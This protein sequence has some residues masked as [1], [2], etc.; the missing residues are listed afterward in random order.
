MFNCC[1]GASQGQ[2]ETNWK[3]VSTRY[4]RRKKFLK[5]NLTRKRLP[6]SKIEC[7]VD[8]DS[9]LGKSVVITKNTPQVNSDYRFPKNSDYRFPQQLCVQYKDC[10]FHSEDISRLR[11]VVTTAM[12][13][14][15]WSRTRSISCELIVVVSNWSDLSILHNPL[16]LTAILLHNIAYEFTTELLLPGTTSMER[17]ISETWEWA[18]KLREAL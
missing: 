5:I 15:V 4:W 18:W 13:A 7:K 6:I 3:H 9:R 12:S 2:R 8:I 11:L 16:G 1:S 14:T 10:R 17:N